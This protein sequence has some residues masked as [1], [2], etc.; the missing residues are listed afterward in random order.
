MII[1]SQN[2]V[3]FIKEVHLAIKKILSEEIGLQVRGDRFYD[4]KK[5][6]SYPISIV[7]YNNTSMLGYFDPSFYELGFHENLMHMNEKQRKNVIRHE[8]AHY[9]TFI[10]YG[11]GIEAHGAE[12]KNFCKNLG[13]DEEVSKAR[14][15]LEDVPQSPSTP[16]DTLRKVQKLLALAESSNAFE[17]ELA[18][19]K[20]RELLL[21]LNIDAS[22]LNSPEE[23]KILL[24]RVLKQ[25]QKTAKLR[26]IAKILETF[27][28]SSVFRQGSDHVCLEILG[29]ETNV[30]IAEYVAHALDQKMDILWDQIKHS[31]DLKGI[32][33]KN[34]F[35]LGLAKGYCDKIQHLKRSYEEST[36]NALIVLEKKLQSA[37]ALVYPSLR[38]MRTGSRYDREAS[39]LGEKAGKALNI[40]PGLSEKTTPSGFT[41]SYK[42]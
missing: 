1:Y 33:A 19:I 34:S 32:T 2:I 38:S 26:A 20:S 7:I 11:S 8:L 5:R 18:M 39:F 17:A 24:Q 22:A 40:N 14:I 3:L 15:C 10:K 31:H 37:Q 4:A 28:V 9:L 13:W 16:S 42:P 35:F 6:C 12:F 30:R 27:F 36:S 41:I 29:S 25:K 23:E 21:K